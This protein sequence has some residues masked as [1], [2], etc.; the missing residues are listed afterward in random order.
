L[1]LWIKLKEL[2]PPLPM[3]MLLKYYD[4]CSPEGSY[5]V[6]SNDDIADVIKV[7]PTFEPS[8]RIGVCYVEGA[9]HCE[10]QIEFWIYKPNINHDEV[11]QNAKQYFL[12]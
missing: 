8:E 12:Q 2:N 7:F 1:E 6:L 11:Y 5:D 10:I 9:Q 3:Y 4:F